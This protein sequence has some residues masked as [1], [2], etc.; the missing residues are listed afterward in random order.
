MPRTAWSVVTL[1]SLSAAP[2]SAGPAVADLF[3]ADTLAFAE[4]REPAK[5][6]PQI[7]AAVAGSRLDDV[8]KLIDAHRDAARTPHALVGK[9]ELAVLGL[10]AAPEFAAEVGKFGGVGAGLTGF[11]GNGEPEAAVAVLTGDSAAAGLAARGFLSLAPVRRVGAVGGVPVYQFRTPRFSFDPNNGQ[12]KLDNDKPPEEG[13]YEATAAYTPGLFVYGT[14]KSAVA[15]VLTRYQ[16][17]GG[18]GLG[19]VAA[20]RAARDAHQHPGVFV[21]ADVPALTARLDEARREGNAGL[22][23]EALGWFRLLAGENAVRYVAGTV[24]FRDGGLAAELSASHVPGRASPLSAVLSGPAV[25]SEHLGHAPATAGAAGTVSLPEKD[26]A[27]AVLGFLDAAVKASGGLGRTPSETLKELEDRFKTPVA[28]ALIGKTHAVTMFTPRST[29][30]KASAAFPTVVLH[31]A[32]PAVAGEWEDFLPKLV[33]GLDGGEPVQPSSEVIDGVK[34]LSLPGTGL[35][36]RAGLHYARKGEAVAVGVERALVAAAVTAGPAGVQLPADRP[37][38]LAGFIRVGGVIRVLRAGSQPSGPVVPLNQ[39]PVPRPG[40]QPGGVGPSSE[41]QQKAEEKALDTLW[42]ALDGLPVATLTARRD[43]DALRVEFVQTVG[44]DGLAPV[45]NAGV[46][47]FD[48]Y[49]DRNAHLTPG[50]SGGFRRF[51]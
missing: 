12:Q 23:P 30:D 50:G 32:S 21:Y 10:L 4:L 2:A 14:S 40:F 13:A 18:T 26:R 15:A 34:V 38:A 6:A 22:E 47:W 39:P 3:P 33:A 49:L 41:G 7:T 11:T 42:A 24:R 51:R 17:K 43:G 31:A 19:G 44:K 46:G 45:I 37:A 36:W 8:T 20:F 16:G 28:D 48:V 29:T 27:A 5:V 25:K 35:P 1:L 9:P